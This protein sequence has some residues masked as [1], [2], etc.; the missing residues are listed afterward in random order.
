MMPHLRLRLCIATLAF[1]VVSPARAAQPPEPCVVIAHRGASG[2]LPEHTL[3]A[4]RLAIQLGADFIEPDLVMTRDGILVARHERQLQASTNVA[5]LPEFAARRATQTLFGTTVTDWFV[6][7]F[8][9]A[10]LQQLRV[11]ETRPEVRP[12]N[13]AFNDRFSI[14]TL[15]EVI[16]VLR[17]E[18]KRSGRIVGLYP[19]L[20]DPEVFRARGLDPERALLA[21]LKGIAVPVY[22]QSFDADSLRRL[23]P[24]TTL[25]LVQ[26][27]DS[28]PPDAAPLPPP[29]FKAIAAYAQGLG[30][31]KA[32]ITGPGEFVAR[33]REAGLFVHGWTFRGE[34]LYLSPAFR[35]GTDPVAR[36]NLAGEIAAALE[37]GM[38]GFFTD[39]PD[40]GRQVCPM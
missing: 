18:G 16:G 24:L 17:E 13:V 39:Q 29:D 3:L 37:R 21:E 1:A 2:Y 8:T 36:G 38:T 20:K 26:L 14:P 33:A 4:Y 11:R 40:V 9:L 34:N 32:L 30:V 5:E 27:L 28:A 12:G 15:A 19:E 7:D 10:E 23:R 22:I 25:P 31:P 6:E 35:S